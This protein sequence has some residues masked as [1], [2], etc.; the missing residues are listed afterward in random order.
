VTQSISLSNL[1]ANAIAHLHANVVRPQYDRKNLKAGIFHFGMGNFHRAHQAVYTDEVLAG[2]GGNWMII[3]ASLF[4]PTTRDLLLSQ[5][6]LYTVLARSRDKSTLRIVGSIKDVLFAPDNPAK[7]IEAMSN[8]DIKIISLTITEKGYLIIPQVVD[9]LSTDVFSAMELLL[10]GL[11]RR[12]KRGYGALTLVS[13]DNL[14]GNGDVLKHSL[15][16]LANTQDESLVSWIEINVS[17]PNSMVDRMVPVPASALSMEVSGKLGVID[18]ACLGTETFSQWVMEDKFIAGRPAWE[19]AGVT[20]SDEVHLHELMKLRLLNGAHSSMAYLGLLAGKVTIAECIAMP[21][22]AKFI[23]S[24]MREE[25]AP[26][27]TA[28]SGT[29]TAAYIPTLLKRF[30]NHYLAHQCQQVAMDGSQKLA[31]RL[32]GVASER[33]VENQPIDGICLVIAA[34]ILYTRGLDEFGESRTVVDPLAE[35]LH[36]LAVQHQRQPEIWIATLLQ[37]GEVFPHSLA[38]SATFKIALTNS[39]CSLLSDG[40]LSTLVKFNTRVAI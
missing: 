2:S 32:Y 36:N 39:L 23:N 29:S 16:R 24:L 34:W 12:R 5:D 3:G 38:Q 26:Q 17:F 11:Q 21:E 13:C 31:Q 18:Q 8:K 20:F 22:I 7:L 33:L 28:P 19:D 15:L 4:N 10:A 25:I 35:Q 30:S 1:N 37:G 40:V 14:V 6:G 9:S 27:V